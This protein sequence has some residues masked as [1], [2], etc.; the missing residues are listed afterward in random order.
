VFGGPPP[1]P[2]AKMGCSRVFKLYRLRAEGYELIQRS[3]VPELV[4]LNLALLNR[5]VLLGETD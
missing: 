1:P 3:E 4:D 2:L 5:C